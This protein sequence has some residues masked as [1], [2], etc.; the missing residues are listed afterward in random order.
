MKRIL[1]VKDITKGIRLDIYLSENI[2]GKSRSYFKN[3]IEKEKVT[4][5]KKIIKSNYKVKI[6]DEIEIEDFTQDTNKVLP[7]AINLDIIY[8][9]K[10]ILVV[11]KPQ[12]MVV[13]PA[14]ANNNG[15]LVN[16]LLNHC[17]TLSILNGADRP[18]IVHR[19]DKDTSGVLVVAKTDIAHES[20]AKQLKDHTMKRI[21]IALC[22]GVIK[23]DEIIINKPLGRDSKN[24][25]KKAIV[26]G[27]RF[28]ITKVKVV[29]TFKDYTLLECRL[30]T[31][32]THQIRVHLASIGHPLVGD[33]LYGYKKQKFN[34]KGQVLHAAVLGFIHP[35]TKEYME[36]KTDIPK[37]FKDLLCKLP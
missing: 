4:V 9:D 5:N 26:E 20:L 27:G 24:R 35:T 6:Y 8:E 7:E 34:L 14:T 12:G 3:L 28:A 15:T 10:D 18:G 31:G 17:D 37:Y 25:L 13:H 36:F 32:R 21:Y 16:G 2:D 29:N 23:D 33:P 11:N 22:E 30:E 1:Q 19:I